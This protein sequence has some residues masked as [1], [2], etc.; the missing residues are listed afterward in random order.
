VTFRFETKLL[1]SSR[2]DDSR[3]LINLDLIFIA[4]KRIKNTCNNVGICK[5]L[6][7]RLKRYL[8]PAFLHNITVF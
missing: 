3:N 2:Q 1:T 5:Q 6:K 7:N 8:K 4:T